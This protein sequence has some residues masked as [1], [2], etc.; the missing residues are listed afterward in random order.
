M[1]GVVLFFGL[2]HGLG[3]ANAFESM[4]SSS[5]STLLSIVEFALGIEIGQLIIVFCALFLS[6][7]AQNIVRFSNRDWVL[8]SSAIILGFMLPAIFMSPLFS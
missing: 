2:I 3:F 6:F 7:I 1:Y 4:V 5:E 8:V